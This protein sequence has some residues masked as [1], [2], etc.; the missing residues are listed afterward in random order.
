MDVALVSAELDQKGRAMQE[1]IAAWEAKQREIWARCTSPALPALQF[2]EELK[3]LLGIAADS[4]TS[5]FSYMMKRH[6]GQ[7]GPVPSPSDIMQELTTAR[8]PSLAGVD[9]RDPSNGVF[10]ANVDNLI[11]E[12]VTVASKARNQGVPPRLLDS[13]DPRPR[14]ESQ[15]YNTYMHQTL[16][17]RAAVCFMERH[18]H[19]SPACHTSF[20]EIPYFSGF[21]HSHCHEWE[22][23]DVFVQVYFCKQA[24]FCVDLALSLVC[25]IVWY[26]IVS[27]I[28]MAWCGTTGY[29]DITRIPEYVPTHEQAAGVGAA[30]E[31]A[32]VPTGL[33]D[34]P[35][36][37]ITGKN[38]D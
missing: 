23:I 11:G 29:E 25:S 21:T 26:G 6:L 17:I 14:K 35:T 7:M 30:E 16:C 36:L 32:E 10:F 4:S 13:N 18:P 27:V 31:Q 24:L 19:Q 1:V 8:W 2:C 15:G 33:P 38:T 9:T 12:L 3:E 5:S 22:Y 37:Q 20:A 34:A 28:S